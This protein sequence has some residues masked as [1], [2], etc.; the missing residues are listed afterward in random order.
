MSLKEII[1]QIKSKNRALFQFN[2]A[3]FEQFKGLVLAVEEL[4]KPVI[5]GFS[6]HEREYLGDERIK[7]L[8]EVE[9]NKGLPIF[10]SADH[11]RT[12]KSA[13]QAIE[14]GFDLIV[15]DFSAFDLKENI[16]LTRQV[17]NLA[18]SKNKEILIE[19]ELGCLPGKSDIL[20]TKI[21]VKK[22]E[23]TDPKIA[24][25]FVQETGVDLFAPAVGNI[26]GISV[27]SSPVI[28]FQRIKEIAELAKIPLVLHGGSGIENQDLQKAVEEGITI[29]HINTEI[30]KKWKSTLLE[31]LK[32][33]SVVPYQ[34]LKPVVLAIKEEIKKKIQAL[35]IRP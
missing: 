15:A 35:E 23:L 21:E 20:E 16:N 10:S 32:T 3:T 2:V 12:L 11:C 9:K 1:Y 34:I 13:T 28:D 25:Q 14:F 19:G 22:E 31:N 17:V 33:P 7:A 4:N 24:E 5:V 18:K 27:F 8:I 29:I 26:H 30:R 6:E